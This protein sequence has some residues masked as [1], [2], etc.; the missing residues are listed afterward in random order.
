[1]CKDKWNY[2]NGDYKKIFDYYKGIGHNIS[3]YGKNNI[4]APIHSKDLQ[5]EDNG[6]YVR[7]K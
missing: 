5:V 1:M 3:Y 7:H 2:I 6:I 4:I